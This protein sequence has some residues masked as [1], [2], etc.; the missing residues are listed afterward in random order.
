M[1]IKKFSVLSFRFSVKAEN[2]PALILNRESRT[3]N[4]LQLL[5]RNP[6]IGIN[7]HP[8]GN[9]H[10]FFGDLPWLELCMVGQSLRGSLS[11][12]A[13]RTNGGDAGVRLDDISLAAEQVGC[14][15]V[16][17]EKQ[18]F[19][20]TEKLVG[21]PIFCEFDGGAADIPVILL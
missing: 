1:A 2:T 9:F 11:K 21:P 8:A 15:L 3:E 17:D 5:N 12:R 20:M 6:V 16:R 18:R 7:A 10:G 14:V 4:Y 19:Q 13:P